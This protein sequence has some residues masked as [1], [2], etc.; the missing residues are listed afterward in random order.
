MK[1]KEL[2]AQ[3]PEMSEEKLFELINKYIEMVPKSLKERIIEIHHKKGEEALPISNYILKEFDN[4]QDKKSY[5][6]KSQ[7]DSIQGF[8]GMCLIKMTKGED[9]EKEPN[10]SE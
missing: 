9:I 7:R 4:I 6:T 5:L 2:I 10:K 1:V 8:V 3:T